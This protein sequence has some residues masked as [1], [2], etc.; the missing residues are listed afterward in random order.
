MVLLTYINRPGKLLYINTKA[1]LS[2][3]RK[4][5]FNF[6]NRKREWTTLEF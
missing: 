3:E 6:E 2:D 5:G 1:H 4:R